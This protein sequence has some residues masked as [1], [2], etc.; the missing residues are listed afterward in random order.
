MFFSPLTLAD[1]LLHLPCHRNWSQECRCTASTHFWMT[2]QSKFF[3]ES[4]RWPSFLRLRCSRFQLGA[5]RHALPWLVPSCVCSPCDVS[6]PRWHR[7]HHEAFHRL[8]DTCYPESCTKLVGLLWQSCWL[9]Q[10]TM[11]R[12][13]VQVQNLSLLTIQCNKV[14]C[15]SFAS[16]RPLFVQCC[17]LTSVD[18][19]VQYTSLSDTH[20]IM[21]TR[22]QYTPAA[23][24]LFL[25]GISGGRGRRQGTEVQWMM[26]PVLCFLVVWDGLQQRG[27]AS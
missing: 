2:T 1:V 15:F 17:S 14:V 4:S 25:G 22:G 6:V 20:Y 27:F 9:R 26:I 5:H 18:L 8:R 23:V 21:I 3:P 12:A 13:H 7:W 10:P 24:A 11:P 19:R 16:L